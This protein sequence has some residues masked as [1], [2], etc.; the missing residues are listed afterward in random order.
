MILLQFRLLKYFVVADKF[1][2]L[3]CLLFSCNSVSTVSESMEYCSSY[4]HSKLSEPLPI[5]LVFCFDWL[6]F[7]NSVATPEMFHYIDKIRQS[8]D[9]CS[10]TMSAE[11]KKQ[12]L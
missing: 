6:Q 2:N 12:Q 9:K 7:D 5:S 11:H 4:E 10:L 8:A 1:L 3:D